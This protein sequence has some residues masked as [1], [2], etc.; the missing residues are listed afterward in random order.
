MLIF[1]EFS[2]I[3]SK[4]IIPG[5][6]ANTDLKDNPLPAPNTSK[7]EN[8]SESKTG[9]SEFFM[10]SGSN[11][12]YHWTPKT[13]EDKEKKLTWQR[14]EAGKKNYV[15]AQ[16]FCEELQLAGVSDWR[17]PMMSELR[18]L[19]RHIT[20]ESTVYKEIFNQ[21]MDSFFWSGSLT[22]PRVWT[23]N[24]WTGRAGTLDLKQG[25][26]RPTMCVRS[27]ENN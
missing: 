9:D 23:I 17:L 20:S 11:E 15:G 4:L 19:N 5:I 8:L 27:F 22:G 18:E 24:L 7:L 13:V 3:F 2:L 14:R 21:P 10:G 1:F 26:Q 25:D 16:G 12:R 6:T